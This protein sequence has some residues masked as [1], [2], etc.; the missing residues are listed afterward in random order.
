[1]QEREAK[2]LCKSNDLVSISVSN[3]NSGWI[4]KILEK[5]KH[6]PDYLISKRSTDPR[7][8][9]TSDAALR[10]CNRIGFNKVEVFF[11]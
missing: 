11:G 1:M 2:L 8:F 7:V 5:N 6:N 10:C 3:N 9:K 4:I